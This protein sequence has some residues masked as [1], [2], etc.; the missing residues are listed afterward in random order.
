MPNSGFD[1]SVPSSPRRVFASKW[2]LGGGG[3]VVIV[4]LVIAVMS[5]AGASGPGPAGPTGP[6]QG[7]ALAEPSAQ[8]VEPSQSVQPAAGSTAPETGAA[9][10]NPEPTVAPDAPAAPLPG[11]EPVAAAPGV[12][13]LPPSAPA[14]GLPASEALPDLVQEAEPADATAQGRLVEGLPA[15]IGPAP[16]STVT[17][18]SVK[19][20]GGTVTASLAAATSADGT[21]ILAHYEL[22]FGTAGLTGTPATA[23]GGTTVQTFYRANDA[24]TLTVRPSVDGVTAYALRGIFSTRT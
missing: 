6:G 12:E 13:V 23:T 14:T 2:L 24:V 22:A 4:V 5:V 1:S 20:S 15:V 10:A 7:A 17:S 21:E 11:Q 18:S 9:P 16:A 8:P 3:V 19:S